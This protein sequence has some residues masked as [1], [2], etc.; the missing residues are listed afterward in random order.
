M[1]L[2]EIID[3]LKEIDIEIEDIGQ[4]IDG[5]KKSK[6]NLLTQKRELLS[7]WRAINS[8]DINTIGRAIA[9]LL[10]IVDKRPYD[11]CQSYKHV[12]QPQYDMMGDFIDNYEYD[13]P[14]KIIVPAKFKNKKYRDDD[15]STIQL[16]IVL[17]DNNTGL[18]ELYDDT[19]FVSQG[20]E[21]YYP[22][23]KEFISLIRDYR[24]EKNDISINE[25]EIN[26]ILDGYINQYDF[27][28]VSY[29]KKTKKRK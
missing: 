27:E 16:Y 7:T 4:Q 15:F 17:E 14:I 8:Y 11:Y 9:K 19:K 28:H 20:I 1:K 23:I 10:T 18:I 13:I 21:D 25:E 29:V 5:L 24:I 12:S 3:N 6:Q 22:I 26:K 2:T